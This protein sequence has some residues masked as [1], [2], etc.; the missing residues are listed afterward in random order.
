MSCSEQPADSAVTEDAQNQDTSMT[1][2]TRELSWNPETR[3]LGALTREPMFVQHPSGALFVAG[4]GPQSAELSSPRQQPLL[5][6]SDDDGWSWS[7]VDVGRPEDGAMG[8]SDVDLVVDPDGI[9]Y[10]ASMGF[11]RTTFR[12]THIA[13]GVSSD[14]GQTWA[15]SL[16]S[17]TEFDDRPW[18]RVT[19][20]RVAHL[21]WNDGQ[22]VAHAIS[23]DRGRS[24]QELA[25]IHQQGGSSHFATGPSGELAVRISP[26]SASANIYHEG[27]DFIAVSLD[28][29]QTWSKNPPPGQGRWPASP[30]EFDTFQ[31]WVDPMAW[32][33]EGNLHH[34]WSEATTLRIARSSDHGASWEKWTVAEGT[35][36][37]FFPYLAAAGTRLVASWFSGAGD[38]LRAHA[39]TIELDAGQIETRRFAPVILDIWAGSGEA[40]QRSTGGEYLP[41]GFLASG[42]IAMA[43]PIQD[44]VAVRSGFTWWTSVPS[45]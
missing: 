12:G 23:S 34:L 45:P 15:W 26:L 38:G 18:I 33:D 21:I 24:W 14:V 5:W 9:L 13:V 17:E 22:G 4:Y 25:R 11:D 42:Q 8:N 41:V 43:T 37:L 27:A 30:E 1:D 16:V 40:A 6:R 36:P 28:G 7:R 31:R 39:A 10:F 2:P 29:G 3:H 19:P 44:P 32:D 35:E 20:D